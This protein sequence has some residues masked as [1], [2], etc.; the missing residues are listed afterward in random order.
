MEIDSITLYGCSF[1]YVHYSIHRV[2]DGMS[3]AT[4]LLIASFNFPSPRI[5]YLINPFISE[6]GLYSV[7][8]SRFFIA[9]CSELTQ[10]L[11]LST[12]IEVGF[13]FSLIFSLGTKPHGIVCHIPNFY[14]SLSVSFSLCWTDLDFYFGLMKLT[15]TTICALIKSVHCHCTQILFI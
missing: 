1:K 4:V 12:I 3:T 7:F 5:I 14:G 2:R 6:I 8:M 15:F 9:G 10:L 11:E 13:F